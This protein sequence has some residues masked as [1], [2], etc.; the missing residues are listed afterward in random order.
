MIPKGPTAPE[1]IAAVP[2]GKS[3]VN[4]SD[5][6][7][8]SL[9]G[10]AGEWRFRAKRPTRGDEL[11]PIFICA[12]SEWV[13]KAAEA[14]GRAFE[15]FRRSSGEDRS[16]LLEEIAKQLELSRPA[17]ISRMSAETGFAAGRLEREFTRCLA[18]VRM[19][20]GLVREG[21]WVRATMDSAVTG[22]SGAMVPDVRRMLTPI[23]PIGVFPCAPQPLAA[24]VVGTDTVSAL[25]AGCPVV[26]K[27]NPSHAGSGELLARAVVRAIRAL[28]MNPGIFSFLHS[29]GEREFDSTGTLVRHPIIRGV[30]FCGSAEG[31][32]MV[33]RS[34]LER[35][36][37]IP[38]FASVGSPNPVFVLPG[39]A[40]LRGEELAG[41]L[42]TAVLDGGG[43]G[44]TKPAIIFISTQNEKDAGARVIQQMTAKFRESGEMIL[45]SERAVSAYRAGVAALARIEGIKG[46]ESPDAAAAQNEQ[47]ALKQGAVQPFVARAHLFSV[48]FE[49][50]REQPLLRNEVFGPVVLAVR[51]GD[52]V[53]MIEAAMSLPGSVVAS[54][55]ASGRDVGLARRII[56]SIQQSVGRLVF[57]GVTSGQRISH[58]TFDGGPVAGSSRPDATASGSLAIERWTRPV[59]FQNAP[60]AFLPRELWGSNPLKIK[61]QRDGVLG[62]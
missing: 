59:C 20:A 7:E 5:M 52:D 42:A 21:S 38:V 51:C 34:A 22:E 28:K 31:A 58:A 41:K 62:G 50:F 48:P 16:L 55:F 43:Q 4:G 47:R 26:V 24:G 3:I 17:V 36:T 29:G 2:A 61:R 27:G 15:S 44:H 40:A 35:P 45:C 46:S 33:Q 60:E 9:A 23:G 6:G 25:A 39:A 8:E 30:G 18:T 13:T 56:P 53:E 37:G 14:A 57:S 32:A 12:P 19:Y 54:I 11:D 10:N 49:V 1:A